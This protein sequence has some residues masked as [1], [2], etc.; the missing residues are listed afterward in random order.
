MS[1]ELKKAMIEFTH[2]CNVNNDL[3]ISVR[4]HCHLFF[5]NILSENQQNAHRNKIFIFIQ[6]TLTNDTLFLQDYG[7]VLETKMGKF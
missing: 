5:K 6:S 2:S 4:I 7:L 3:R 1:I